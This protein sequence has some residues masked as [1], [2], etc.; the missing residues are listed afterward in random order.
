MTT[1][2]PEPQTLP[3]TLD[4][5][6]AVIGFGKGGKTL[7]AAMAKRG[8][9]VAMIEQSDQMYGGTCINIGCVPT[10]ALVYDAENTGGDLPGPDRY[11][12]AT[13]RT[14]DLTALLRGKNFAMLDTLDTVTVITGTAAFTDAHTLTVQAGDDTMQVTA[15]T[16]VI[17]TGAD[18][19]LPPLPGLRESAHVVTSTQL[20]ARD[21]R[22]DHLVVIGGGYVA[23]EFASMHAAFGAQVTVL[24][25]GD[26]ILRTEDADVAAAAAD[27]LTSSGVTIRTGVTITGIKDDDDR[28]HVTYTDDNGVEQTVPADTVLA[29]LG[30]RPHTDGLNL[31]A[32][33]I[34]TDHRGAIVVDEHL[35]TSQ[36]HVYAIGDV[37]G[38]PQFTYVSLDDYRIV[39]DDLVSTGART[40]ADRKAVA[41]ALFMTPPLARVGLTETEARATGRPLLLAVRQ[42]ADMATVPRARIVHDPRG[43]MK[44][45]VDAETDQILGVTM[46]SHDSHE[47]INTVALA[48]R[49][50]IT[51]TQLRDEIYTHPSMTEAFNDLFANLKPL[52]EQS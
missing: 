31:V 25:R 26:R 5:D 16:I 27:I 44:A 40:T 47:T 45:V 8:A 19:D 13:R 12:Q 49:H 22:P 21:E 35:R 17:N 7:A 3:T 6:L 36:P 23:V 52:Q 42:V 28:A 20:L 4:V 33:G 2:A 46:L 51:A 18:P 9:R 37:N 48:M 32:A 15:R 1:E 38:G 41:S 24:E 34:R 43:L 11:R 50:G 14:D 10:K 39:L 29:A 30:R